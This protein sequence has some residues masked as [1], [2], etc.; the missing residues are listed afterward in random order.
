MKLFNV[1][2][3]KLIGGG[4]SRCILEPPPTEQQDFQIKTDHLI[5]G[6]VSNQ[7]VINKKKKKLQRENK[8]KR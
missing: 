6:K 2:S 8:R 4:Y 1:I 7:E 3:R 5:P